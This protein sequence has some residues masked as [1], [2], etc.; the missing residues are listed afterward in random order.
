MTKYT[1]FKI[2]AVVLIFAFLI[3]ICVIEDRLVITSLEQVNNFCYE[4][5]TAAEKNNGILN[6]EV[7]IL[8]D[9]LED[10]WKKNESSLCFLV[11]HKS[12]EP[13]GVE[14]VKLKAYIDKN[15]DVEF[16]VSLDLIKEYVETFQHFMGANFH[17]IL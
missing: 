15:E 7:A 16:F 3:G 14:I 2:V 10:S 5:E 9:N 4:I 6:E 17:N 1:I 8:V 11:N 12:I 13:L